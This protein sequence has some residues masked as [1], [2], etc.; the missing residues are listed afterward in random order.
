MRMT[1]GR[2]AML[3]LLTHCVLTARAFGLS[4]L[5][6]VYNDFSDTDGFER[7]C[8][9]GRDLGFDGKTLIHPSQIEIANRAFSPSTEDIAFACKIIDIFENPEHRG[10]GAVQIDGRMVERLHLDMAYR[11]I[12]L[13]KMSPQC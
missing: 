10:R 8:A 12:A 1:P 9:Q 7:E 4:I 13:A 6:G 11:T 3:P 2:D 5:D